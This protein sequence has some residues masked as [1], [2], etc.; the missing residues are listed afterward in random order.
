VKCSFQV[1]KEID[2]KWIVIA[3]NSIIV[4]LA[5]NGFVEDALKVFDEMM[6]SNVDPDDVT[7]LGALSACSHSGRV[8]EGCRLFDIMVNQYGIQ[9]RNDHF[10]CMIVLFAR[11]G[12]LEEAES[13][14]AKLGFEPDD[15][16]WASFLG[17]CKLHGDDARGKHA[18][19][20][21]INL[22]PYNSSAYVS[23]SGIHAS[24]GNW[25]EVDSL[26]KQMKVMGVAKFTGSSWISIT[27]DNHVHCLE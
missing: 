17:A 25:N 15:M 7:F 27:E 24:S 1:F 5:K 26:R 23:L 2:Y 6:Q 22:D 10:A 8:A 3:W 21:L 14:I 11:W 4:G 20:K 9:P 12:L 18:A 13:L 19:E 16:I